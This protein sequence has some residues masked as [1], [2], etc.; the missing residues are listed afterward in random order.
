MVVRTKFLCLC[1]PIF[2]VVSSSGY[3][4]SAVGHANERIK[5]TLRACHLDSTCT[6]SKGDSLDTKVLHRFAQ[7]MITSLC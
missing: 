6:A 1:R 7:F 2:L 5:V 3:H 4:N